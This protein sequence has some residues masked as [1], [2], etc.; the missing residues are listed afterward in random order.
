MIKTTHKDIIKSK[1]YMHSYCAYMYF[2]KIHY[3]LYI[4][5]YNKFEETCLAANESQNLFSHTTGQDGSYYHAVFIEIKYMH[6]T[7][8]VF[9]CYIWTLIV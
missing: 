6:I 3:S 8:T 2:V 9:T 7:T 1:L 4:Y 5:P